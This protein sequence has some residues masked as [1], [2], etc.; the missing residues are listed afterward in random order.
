MNVV[1]LQMQA[2]TEEEL[3]VPRPGGPCK[4]GS[5]NLRTFVRTHRNT[6]TEFTKN[7]FHT[8]HL[9]T[10]IFIYNTLKK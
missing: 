4:K 7:W 2:E 8:F 3:P 9:S 10:F 5:P 6:R 1:S